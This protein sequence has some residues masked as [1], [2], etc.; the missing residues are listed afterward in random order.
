[1]WV[2]A[3]QR[4]IS[5]LEENAYDNI[6][7]YFCLEV[8]F[9]VRFHNTRN[10]FYPLPKKKF[11]QFPGK[12]AFFVRFPTYVCPKLPIFLSAFSSHARFAL[13]TCA[14]RKKLSQLRLFFPAFCPIW[15]SAKITSFEGGQWAYNSARRRL[16][17]LDLLRFPKIIET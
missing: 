17:L 15:P 1:M 9:L 14:E 10:P 3:T 5:S 12:N 16:S 4:R 6:H 11:K 2:I 13:P 7:V 8:L